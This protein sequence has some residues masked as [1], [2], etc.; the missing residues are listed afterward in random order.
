MAIGEQVALEHAS[1]ATTKRRR[2]LL[3]P[4]TLSSEAE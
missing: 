2:I 1:V 3:V 4:Q